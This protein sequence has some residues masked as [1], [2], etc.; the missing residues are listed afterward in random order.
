MQPLLRVS[1]RVVNT[2]TSDIN[3]ATNVEAE[4]LQQKKEDE[5]ALGWGDD[6]DSETPATDNPVT[7]STDTRETVS[8]DETAGEEGTTD[9]AAESKPTG[10]FVHGISM[11]WY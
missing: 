1:T 3:S 9:T 11:A 5:L 2:R 7:E 4:E 8:K 10:T 6:D